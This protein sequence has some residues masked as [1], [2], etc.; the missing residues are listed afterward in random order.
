VNEI[1]V[2]TKPVAVTTGVIFPDPK[3]FHDVAAKED[4]LYNAAVNVLP[5]PAVVTYSLNVE[6][7]A[8]GAN[9]ISINN[10]LDPVTI[11]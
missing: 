8:A 3:R 9:P 1:A 4:E 7:V 6:Y 2:D 11:R 10:V 5:V